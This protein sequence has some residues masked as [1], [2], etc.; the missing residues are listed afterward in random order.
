MQGM[1]VGNGMTRLGKQQ[2]HPQN[3]LGKKCTLNRGLDTYLAN[4]TS[5]FTKE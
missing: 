2:R 5:L 3:V 1:P 4:P